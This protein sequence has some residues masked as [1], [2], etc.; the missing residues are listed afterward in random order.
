MSFKMS[1][2][3]AYCQKF[4]ES[5]TALLK[6]LGSTKVGNSI[7]LANTP[8]TVNL[9]YEGDSLIFTFNN[10]NDYD[11]IEWR[12]AFNAT[13]VVINLDDV[14]NH[15]E[16]ES[17][18]RS[19]MTIKNGKVEQSHYSN[20]WHS[21]WGPSREIESELSEEEQ[22]TLLE[23][24]VKLMEKYIPQGEK[25]ISNKKDSAGNVNTF[26]QSTTTSPAVEPAKTAGM[27]F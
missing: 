17:Y 5:R 15:G 11:S 20:H 1:H 4:Y 8:N 23:D 9:S 2:M 12:A 3:I 6:E 10:N 24:L 26:F 25:N 14:G 27:N 21:D 16:C 22:E 13:G 18:I 7:C 19:S